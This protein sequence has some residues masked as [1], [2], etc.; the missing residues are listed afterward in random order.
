MESGKGGKP[1]AHKN[2]AYVIE[3]HQV[4]SMDTNIHNR[5]IE[6]RG[7]KFVVQLE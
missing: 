6:N 7:R 2:G 1:R 5:M 3:D 4:N